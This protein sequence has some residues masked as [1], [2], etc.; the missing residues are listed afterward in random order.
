MLGLHLCNLFLV[1][2]FYRL[3]GLLLLRLA[4]AGGVPQVGW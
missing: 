3:I 2:L 1:I 4:T